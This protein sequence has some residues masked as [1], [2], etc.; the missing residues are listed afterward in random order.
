LKTEA[1]EAD[2]SMDA[3]HATMSIEAGAVLSREG[4]GA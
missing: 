4:C 2:K 1:V 3:S